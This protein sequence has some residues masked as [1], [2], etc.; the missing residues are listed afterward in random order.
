MSSTGVQKARVEAMMFAQES[1]DQGKISTHIFAHTSNW[2]PDAND[3]L[4]HS[5]SSGITLHNAHFRLL[6]SI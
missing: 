3:V 1:S 6:I 5:Q 4:T 2:K